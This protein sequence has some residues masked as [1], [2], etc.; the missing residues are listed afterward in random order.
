[1]RHTASPPS[2][3]RRYLHD[4]SSSVFHGSW[5]SYFALAVSLPCAFQVLNLFSF[6]RAPWAFA[7][8]WA[9]P[10][11]GIFPAG[12]KKAPPENISLQRVILTKKSAHLLSRD[13]RSVPGVVL[14]STLGV[15]N[16]KKPTLLALFP[17]KMADFTA[18][19]S[20]TPTVSPEGTE[21][22][23]SRPLCHVP[24][25][26][27]GT[28][29]HDMAEFA[30]ITPLTGLQSVIPASLS[31]IGPTADG[32]ALVQPKTPIP[33]TAFA[34]KPTEDQIL[35]TP[36][37]NVRTGDP[38]GQESGNLLESV[39]VDS[40]CGNFAEKC[41]TGA[42]KGSESS[43]K[44]ASTGLSSK[45]DQT[46]AENVQKVSKIFQNGSK[47]VRNGPTSVE[48][49]LRSFL[50]LRRLSDLASTLSKLV[51]AGTKSKP[52]SPLSRTMPG[53]RRRELSQ[54]TL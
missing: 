35:P 50:A 10:P 39:P 2:S 42:Q 27:N 17:A 13:F 52:T 30:Q 12:G 44:P 6:H 25:V 29:S 43:T 40:V 41:H 47:M 16:T 38:V 37:S 9:V 24:G 49:S 54:L 23:S 20:H 34:L 3:R 33:A 53:P 21:N 46:S 31:E 18:I 1:M 32:P 28:N 8:Q 11:L 14:L 48:S 26:Q 45:M 15:K 7:P 51:T 5:L 22:I 4:G 19:I 36:L